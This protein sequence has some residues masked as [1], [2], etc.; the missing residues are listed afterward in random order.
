MNFTSH[1]QYMDLTQNLSIYSLVCGFGTCNFVLHML[2]AVFLNTLCPQTQCEVLLS[3]QLHK[4]IVV[5]VPRVS[6]G[7]FNTWKCLW[8][9]CHLMVKGLNETHSE[10]SLVVHTRGHNP[11]APPPLQHLDHPQSSTLHCTLPPHHSHLSLSKRE[12]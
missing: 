5:K 2:Y 4:H 6:K 10:F 12:M 9:N 7:C 1:Q 8:S 3:L 11:A